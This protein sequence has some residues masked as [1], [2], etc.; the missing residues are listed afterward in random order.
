MRRPTNNE[1]PPYAQ[2][3]IEKVPEGKLLNHFSNVEAVKFYQGIPEDKWDYAYR[4]DKWNIKEILHHIVD[5]ERVFLYRSMRVA[6]NDETP[7]AGFEQDDYVKYSEAKNR[8]AA[9]LIEEFEVTRKA[10]EVFYRSLSEHAWFKKGTASGFVFTPI[11]GAYMI[12]GH[13]IH[14]RQ[15]ISER[16]L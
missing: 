2:K 3:Y 14:H 12:I 7:M 10:C 4:E 9:S 8:S 16:Y 6:R 1:Y 13:E 5:S 15:I 11:G